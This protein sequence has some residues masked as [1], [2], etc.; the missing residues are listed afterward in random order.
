MQTV[1]DFD[2]KTGDQMLY[3]AY[4]DTLESGILDKPFASDTII[5]Q[6]A[7][8]IPCPGA[9]TITYGSQ[10]Y[11]TIQIL[12]QCWMKENLNVGLRIDAP[13][14]MQTNN[15]IIE[16]YCYDNEPDSCTKYGGIYQWDEIMD[17]TTEEGTRGICPDGW[18]VPSDE[19]W[20]VL[21]GTADS[22]FGI[23]DSEWDA[24]N[25]RGFDAGKNLKTISGWED[26][27][28][29]TDL[30]NFSGLP[31]GGLWD[32]WFGSIGAFGSWWTS[33]ESGNNLS[34]DHGF[35]LNHDDVSRNNPDKENGYSV[36]CIKDRNPI[37]LD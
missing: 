29:G 14:Q 21:E 28:N 19:E 27:G 10:T 34:W 18:H 16:K 23:G 6:F 2:F 9:S 3:V 24:Y 36:R 30:F 8:N 11:N 26:G 15:D 7:T 33:T 1:I 5:F 22:Q 25:K 20:K 17:Y 37:M 4:G 12:S 31:G 32:I 35:G 13:D